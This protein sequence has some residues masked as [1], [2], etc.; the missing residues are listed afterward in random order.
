MNALQWLRD[1]LTPWLGPALSRRRPPAD[2]MGR[3]KVAALSTVGNV[4][5]LPYLDTL[6]GETQAMRMAYRLMLRDPTVKAALYSKLFGVA[7]LDLQVTPDGDGPRAKKVA[8]FVKYAIERQQGGV[9]GMVETILVG[10]LIE[11][12]SVGE[13]V[14]AYYE[15]G[16]WRGQYGL[17]A[18]KGK[19]PDVYRPAVDEFLNL[20]CVEA[21]R[22]PAETYPA[23]LFVHCKHLPIYEHPFG[24]S[25]LRAAYRAYWLIDTSW[26]LRAIHL[27]KYTSPLLKGEYT[28]A[29]DKPAL[30][31]ALEQAKARTWLTIPEGAKVEAL[32]LANRGPADYRDAIKDMQHEIMLGI[33]GAILQAMEGNVTG[34]RSIG[35]VHKSSAELIVW[36]LADLACDTANWQLVPDLVDLN[37][38]GAG[39]PLIGLGGVN[40]ADLEPSLK[41]DMGLQ[42]MGLALSRKEVYQRYNRQLPEDDG[43]RLEPPAPGGGGGL[44]G[45]FDGPAGPSPG[46]PDTP[47]P[48]LPPGDTPPDEPFADDE[49]GILT[50][51]VRP[52]ARPKALPPAAKPAA[53]GDVALAGKDGQQA[54]T[55]LRNSVA[56]GRDTLLELSEAA[57]GRLLAKPRPGAAKKLFTVAELRE[58]ADHLAACNATADL[59]G[60][61]RIRRRAEAVVGG[62]KLFAEDVTP[63]CFA[64]APA[65]PLPPKRALDYFL[66]LVPSLG[67]DPKRFGP[68]HERSAFTL[69]EAAETV[70][71][72]KV[73]KAIAE[74]IQTGEAGTGKQEVR[75]LLD[76]AGVGGKDHNYA[77]M[78]YRTNVM[79]SYNAGA[80]RELSSGDMPD[81][82]PVW[83]YLGI[84]D[85]RQGKD[86]EPQFDKFFESSRPFAEVRGPRI[87]NCRCSFSP[88]AFFEWQELQARGVTT[89]V[90][91]RPHA[92][93]VADHL[94]AGFTGKVE[95]SLGRERCYQD[96]KQV[97][98]H[99][100]PEG[101]RPAP[102]KARP[103]PSGD[104]APHPGASHGSAVAVKPAK[105]RAWGGKDPVELK[106]TLTKQ[107]TGRVG[108]AVALAW[109]KSQGFADARPM[110]SAAT[111][112]PIDLIE[113][114][115]PTEVK[116]GLASNGRGAQQ[117][118]LTFSKETA[119]EKS[120]YEKMTPAERERWNAEKQKRI[121]ERKRRVIAD[122]QKRNP[123][124]PI[125]PRTIT[126]VLNPDTRTAD[127]FVFDGFHDRIDWQSAAA[128]SAYRGSVTYA[129]A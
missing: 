56:R 58:F 64:D 36:Y 90:P 100:K 10:A 96:G 128:K 20:R 35:E 43:D 57:V 9:R 84:K 81:V 38:A 115:A 70:L 45:L 69:A 76:A 17:K 25:D 118:R 114:H 66:S 87:F 46:G 91:V 3:E 26:K 14:W 13:K 112:F 34:A 53:G 77:D 71:L 122:L 124:T 117:W 95:D 78:V 97:P 40:D 86:H 2:R 51:P 121:H 92:E 65:T 6:T 1:T 28:V 110:N 8:R 99:G 85:G 106:T 104:D 94:F 125:K 24:M 73:Q 39:R 82:F 37:F 129:A 55:L 108:E 21:I 113:D 12:F 50:A 105:Q 101:G 127:V 33:T 19:N 32:D 16:E 72:Q 67:V 98:C 31:S 116:A 42:Q 109:L 15:H 63:Q 88:V 60:R 119:A 79:D 54:G 4:W 52:L 103:E 74:S 83:K 111:N 49:V 27:E 80:Q 18:L 44:G 62:V 75:R 11:G 47:P 7:S 41:V 48:G 22:G 30:E 89:S 29:T 68:L 59:L 23:E 126:V 93:A 120:A 5:F 102:G 61:S 123:R 107:E